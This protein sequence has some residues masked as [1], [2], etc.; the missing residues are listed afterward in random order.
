LLTAT[1]VEVA[2][3]LVKDYDIADMLHKL[4]VR[5]V[6]IFGVTDAG[7]MLEDQGGKL[8]AVASSSEGALSMEVLQLHSESG[9]CWEAAKTGVP[10]HVP[11]LEAEA[12]RW[13][14]Y[15][16][17][18][19]ELGLRSVHAL[20][21]RLRDRAMGALN[22]FRHTKGILAQDDLNAMQA[23]ADV[24][25]ISLL[26]TRAVEEA[27][28]S[29]DQLQIALESRVVIEQAK[30]IVSNNLDLDMSR[31]FQLLRTYARSHNLKLTDVCKQVIDGAL[32]APELASF[33]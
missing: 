10:V 9:P 20:P 1:F 14:E 17:R 13:P 26:Q 15:V 11:D 18:G 24:A 30:G 12:E 33:G 27:E 3:N 23:L 16:A 6:E 2:D 19:L 28:V 29:A 22:V 32:S 21:L 25:T 5:C 4:V 31:S 7:I 8:K